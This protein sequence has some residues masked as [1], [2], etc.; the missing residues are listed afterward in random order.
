MATWDCPNFFP[1]QLK[2]QKHFYEHDQ[3]FNDGV[4][5]LI[6]AETTDISITDE[7]TSTEAIAQDRICQMK[8]EVGEKGEKGDKG[9]TGEKGDKGDKGDAGQSAPYPSW[10]GEEKPSYTASEIGALPNTGGIINGKL[11]FPYSETLRGQQIEMASYGGG[12]TR[13]A[14]VSG[15]ELTVHSVMRSYDGSGKMINGIGVMGY[16]DPTKYGDNKLVYYT[17]INEDLGAVQYD[18]YHSGNI[19]QQQSLALSTPLATKASY[20]NTPS[21]IEAVETPKQASNEQYEDG[22]LIKALDHWIYRYDITPNDGVFVASEVAIYGELTREN[23]VRAVM[24]AEFGKGFELNLIND[25]NA[26]CLGVDQE[27]GQTQRYV[28]FL[29]RR[30]VLKLIIANDLANLE[31]P[32]A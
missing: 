26:V 10:I 31:I 5:N 25:Y 20:L 18:V 3:R 30:E 16:V 9:E 19:A 12:S 4:F 21:P 23:V 2:V 11:T 28:D 24:E 27:D 14:S 17:L 13:I 1:G 22:E 15:G 29:K 6:T 7:F 8:G 32:Q